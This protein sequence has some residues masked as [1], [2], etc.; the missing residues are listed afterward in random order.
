MNIR[1][2]KAN[3]KR[4]KTKKSEKK[5]F[6]SEVKKMK[7]NETFRPRIR[8][9]SI[10]RSVKFKKNKELKTSK[11]NQVTNGYICFKQKSELLLISGTTAH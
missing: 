3:K 6:S 7:K 10:M 1:K 8:Q 2:I 11:K 4:N 9:N 5:D